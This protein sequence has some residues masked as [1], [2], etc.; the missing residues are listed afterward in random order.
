MLI[1]PISDNEQP[2]EVSRLGPM[3]LTIQAIQK[4]MVLRVRHF[5]FYPY[6][7]AQSVPDIEPHFW[8]FERQVTGTELAQVHVVKTTYLN[9]I[10]CCCGTTTF[11]IKVDDF[12]RAISFTFFGFGP[13]RGKI[14]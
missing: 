3:A 7:N 12:F 6:C 1:I 10:N 2:V 13:G 9:L 4:S 11:F 14:L 8:E 5:V